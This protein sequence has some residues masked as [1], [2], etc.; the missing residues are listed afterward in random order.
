VLFD[1]NIGASAN[2]EEPQMSTWNTAQPIEPGLYIA[3]AFERARPSGDD[4]HSK[5][6]PHVRYWTGRHWTPP[7]AVRD[8]H[9][10]G[11]LPSATGPIARGET[12]RVRR[13]EWLER[14]VFA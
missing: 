5:F 2:E 6:G 12:G 8:L 3:R 1:P 4:L 14:F 7:C 13:V 10:P 11:R 9:L